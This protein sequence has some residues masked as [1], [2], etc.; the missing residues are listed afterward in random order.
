MPSVLTAGRKP[1]VGG[2]FLPELKSLLPGHAFIERSCVAAFDEPA[3]TEAVRA[4]GRQTVIMA[5]V[6]TD[7]G[8][9]YAA[10]GAKASGYDVIAVLDAS[11]TTDTQAEELARLRLVHEGIRLTGWA[12]LATGLMGDFAGPQSL[13]TMALLAQRMDTHS[14]PFG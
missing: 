7:I 12:S 6:A 11:A 13:D 9:L 5:G 1:G 10:L 14:G 4:T 8:V 3:L 2:V